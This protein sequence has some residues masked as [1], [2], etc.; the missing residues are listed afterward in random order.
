MKRFSLLTIASIFTSCLFAQEPQ[1]GTPQEKDLFPSQPANHQLAEKG[2][3][4]PTPQGAL[5]QE[6][7]DFFPENATGNQGTSP[8]MTQPN[9][10]TPQTP[11]R[12]TRKATQSKEKQEKPKQPP[13]GCEE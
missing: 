1:V 4:P 3:F 2:I 5:P 9:S 7:K 13:Q 8:K 10:T 11:S 12:P 6:E